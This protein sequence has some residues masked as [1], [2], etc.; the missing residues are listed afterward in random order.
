MTGHISWAD[1]WSL[2]QASRSYDLAMAKQL[3]L[4]NFLDRLS[5]KIQLEVLSAAPV[6][7]VKELKSHIHPEVYTKLVGKEIDT[8]SN[9]PENKERIQWQLGKETIEALRRKQN[10]HKM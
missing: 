2:L 6:V 9:S 7:V 5:I 1:L 10:A 8:V 4:E 3:D